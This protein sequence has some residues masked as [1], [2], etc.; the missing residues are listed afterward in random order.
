MS[1]NLTLLMKRS[2]VKRTRVRNAVMQWQKEKSWSCIP[3]PLVH[4]IT[5]VYN[6]SVVYKELQKYS[7]QL[8]CQTLVELKLA[9]PQLI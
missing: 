8:M 2:M 7:K 1:V 5:V 6:A 3:S 4:T 9:L